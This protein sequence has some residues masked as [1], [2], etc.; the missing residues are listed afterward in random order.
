MDQS[1]HVD[2]FIAQLSPELE[3]DPEVEGIVDRIG[4]LSR[5]IKRTAEETIAESA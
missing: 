3:L 2:H 1:D 5:R 4:G